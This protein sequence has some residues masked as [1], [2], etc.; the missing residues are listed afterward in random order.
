MHSCPRKDVSTVIITMGICRSKL[1]KTSQGRKTRLN[2]RLLLKVR[3][4]G[5]ISKVP[6]LPQG[7]QRGILSI[8]DIFIQTGNL[9]P[10][11]GDRCSAKKYNEELFAFR[12]QGNKITTRG[13]EGK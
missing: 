11:R 1:Q 3:G 2:R 13:K 5:L 12:A 7:R 8:E 4:E 6:V 9:K 10:K